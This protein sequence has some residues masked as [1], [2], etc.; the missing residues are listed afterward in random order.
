MKTTKTIFRVWKSGCG[1]GEVIALFPNENDGY[2][3]GNCS[4]YE[5]VGQHGEASYNHVIS[6][7][8]PATPDEYK[9]LAEEL[10]RIGYILSIK[11]RG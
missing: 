8:R 11:Q 1:K 2:P 9:D 7:T 6:Q 3:F 5:H 10:T 4:S